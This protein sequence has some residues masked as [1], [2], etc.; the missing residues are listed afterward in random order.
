MS[1]G[2]VS[3]KAI[4]SLLTT[5]LLALVV[6]SAAS[7]AGADGIVTKLAELPTV[8]QSAIQRQVGTAK[9]G[10][11]T[12]SVEKGEV[13]YEVE[14]TTQRRARSFTIN[15]EGELLSVEVFLAELSHS[16]QQ[17]IR[18]HVGK[19]VLNDISKITENGV[20]TYE[21]EMTKQGKTRSFTLAADGKLQEMQLFIEETPPA[22][23]KAIQK[24]MRGGK[25]GEIYR[26]TEDGEASYDAEIIANGKSRRLTFD[27][28]GALVYQAEPVQLSDTP[29]AVQ[30]TLQEQLRNAKLSSIEKAIE[31]GELTYEVELI[32]LGKRQSLSIKRDGQIVQPGTE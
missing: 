12:K 1:T 20:V 5:R 26:I 2:F 30:Q 18:A 3:K 21:V 8:A 15:E 23:R 11:I 13:V 24:E 22:V 17:A 14:M 32:R 28:G 7:A 25:C 27:A 31:D 10:D 29:E 4:H 19:G 6:L 9:L 16:V